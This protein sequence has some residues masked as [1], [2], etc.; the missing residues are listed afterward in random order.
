MV[1]LRLK[2]KSCETMLLWFSCFL[3]YFH[4]SRFK[5]YITSY[6]EDYHNIKKWVSSEPFWIQMEFWFVNLCILLV[7]VVLEL[8]VQHQYWVLSKRI[9]KSFNRFSPVTFYSKKNRIWLE[10]DR[11]KSQIGRVPGSP[12]PEP[13]PVLCLEPTNRESCIQQTQT[14]RWIG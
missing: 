7:L 10:L 12:S 6:C 14:I 2:F 8:G 11:L 1:Q 9:M 5:I 4:R 13:A 3:F